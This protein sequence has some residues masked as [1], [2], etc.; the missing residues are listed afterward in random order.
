MDYRFD[1]NGESLTMIHHPSISGVVGFRLDRPMRCT[2]D[3]VFTLRNGQWFTRGNEVHGR[4]VKPAQKT[5]AE[6]EMKNGN[7][8]RTDQMVS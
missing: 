1:T 6:K 5:T 8:R 4:W 2:M 3:D 7:H